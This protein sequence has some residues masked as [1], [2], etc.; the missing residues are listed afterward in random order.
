[1]LFRLLMLIVA[2]GAASALYA[3]NVVS[4]TGGSGAVGSQVTL[5]VGLQTAGN[6]AVAAE[7]HIPLPAEVTSAGECVVNTSRLPV[8]QVKA[9]ARS[10]EYVIVIFDLA[11]TPFTAGKGEAVRFTLNLGENPGVFDLTPTVKLSNA[12][13]QAVD[14]TAVGESLTVLGARLEVD[15]LTLDFGRV[16]IRGTYTRQVTV[17]NTGTTALQ[18][19]PI[20]T[21][22]PG[23]SAAPALAELPAGSSTQLV[24]TYSPTV[25]SA[26]ETDRLILESNS[27]G[28]APR[29]IVTAEPFSVNELHV[30]SAEGISDTEV[31]ISLRMNNMEPIVAAQASFV[32]PQGLEYVDGSA[33][34]ADRASALSVMASVDDSRRLTVYLYS[35]SNTAVDGDDGELLTFRLL[36]TGQSNTH[37]LRPENVVL[38]NAAGENMVSATENGRVTIRAPYISGSSTLSLGNQSITGTHTFDYTVRNYGSAPL[39]IERVV[40]PDGVAVC[41]ALL[42]ATVAQGGTFTLPITI[43]DP[44]LGD[45]N[46]TVNIYSN[47]PNERVKSV[48]VSGSFYSP[49]ELVFTGEFVDGVFVMGAYLLNEAP[50]TAVQ[51]DV[52]VPEGVTTSAANLKM[53]E[54]AGS[55]SGTL[56]AVGEGRYRVIVFSL[57]NAAFSGNS[58]EIFTIRFTPGDADPRAIS[59]ENIKLSG[60]D[61]V[62]YTTPDSQTKR[63]RGVEIQ[64]APIQVDGGYQAFVSASTFGFADEIPEYQWSVADEAIAS[65][66]AD[67]TI[68]GL[69]IG[70]T[71]LKLQAT[72][73]RGV[74]YKASSPLY[75][76]QV[77]GID[78][79]TS[80]AAPVEYFTLQGIRIE[81]PSAPG[82]YL[83][84]QGSTITKVR[85][86]AE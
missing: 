16:P 1:M 24:L 52:V 34:A 4:V 31:T 8:H 60:N 9:E 32:L 6:D 46:S 68:T 47:A 71:T 48:T 78:D 17:R 83:R 65:V 11:A 39:Q 44:L 10:G 43:A 62:D 56:A 23:L 81:R 86:A 42:P 61:G 51:M 28:R 30:G 14:A 50:I 82:I 73:A 45:F 29:L 15:A 27:V 36:L 5:S 35:L 21:A 58:G 64:N 70:E 72:D 67:G 7:I 69:F 53:A 38:A 74:T 54:R 3:G 59:V 25:R 66:S 77:S 12:A 13:G 57:S 40:S 80:N 75:V 49:N 84:R 33:A 19:S 20:A 41:D 55:H 26:G 85:I 37:Y 76:L 18:F 79:A 2:Y 63:V 22:M